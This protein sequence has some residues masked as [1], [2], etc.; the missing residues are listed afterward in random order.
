MFEPDVTFENAEKFSRFDLDHPLSSATGTIQLEGEEWPSAEHYVQIHLAGSSAMAQKIRAAGS[1]LEAYNM[2]RSW[3]RPKKK[4]WKK[5]RRVL[6]TRALYTKAQMYPEVKDFLLHTDDSLIA[7]TSL[8]D[9]YWGIGRDQRGENICGKVW[10]D[11][12][13]KFKSA[14]T[15]NSPQ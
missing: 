15:E 12:R 9:H 11:I 3:F 2:N 4:G 8:Y 13:D 5:L 7:E 14:S 6:M 1:A 10:M